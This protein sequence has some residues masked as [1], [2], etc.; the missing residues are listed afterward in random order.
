VSERKPT[1]VLI[2]AAC[3][4]GDPVDVAC[5]PCLEREIAKARA[6]HI[7]TLGELQESIA[8]CNDLRALLADARAVLVDCRD[9]FARLGYKTD[10]LGLDIARALQLID[11]ASSRKRGDR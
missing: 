9:T 4:H 8:E 11:E 3:K 2:Y 5:L 10:T 1:N 7:T 6:D